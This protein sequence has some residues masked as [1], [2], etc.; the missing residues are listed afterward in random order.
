MRTLWIVG[1][2]GGVLIAGGAEAQ[3]RV[4]PPNHGAFGQWRGDSHAQRQDLQEQSFRQQQELWQL[5][6]AQWWHQWQEQYSQQRRD[7]DDSYRRL[8]EQGQLQELYQRVLQLEQR[9][10]Y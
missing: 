2:L 5:Q 8:R 9:R 10:A 6:Q 1:M 3:P 7:V 4:R